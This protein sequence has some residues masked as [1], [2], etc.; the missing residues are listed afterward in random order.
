MIGRCTLG[1]GPIQSESYEYFHKITG[2]FELSKRMAAAEFLNAYIKFDKDEMSDLDITD[3]K[4]SAKGDNILYIV[5]DSPEKILNLRRRIADCQDTRIKTR[6]F[7]PPQFYQRYVKLGMIGR[8][9]R[10][11][12]SRLKTQIRFTE[13]DVKLFVKLKGVDEPFAEVAMEVIEKDENLPDIEYN[14]VWKRKEDQPK[15][16]R[17]SPVIREVNL[18][19]LA[20]AGRLETGHSDS[21]RMDDNRKI[22]GRDSSGNSNASSKQLK[23]KVHKMSSDSSKSNNEMESSSEDGS[24]TRRKNNDE[25]L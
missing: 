2:D 16:R 14:I 21:S 17:T 7:I 24:P 22:R 11:E 20:G 12:N 5:M 1:I 18:K 9:M 3:T 13:D 19:S 6:D 15:W 4:I 25:V 10:S 8:D 23:K